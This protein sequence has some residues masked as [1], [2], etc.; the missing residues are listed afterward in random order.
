MDGGDFDTSE[1]RPCNAN[2]YSDGNL[3]VACPLGGFTDPSSDAELATNVTDCL[4]PQNSE[5]V[6]EVGLNPITQQIEPYVRA[7][8]CNKGYGGD[9]TTLVQCTQCGNSAYKGE[10][11]NVQCTACP[12]GSSIAGENQAATDIGECVCQGNSEMNA[13]MGRCER[14]P[15]KFR[16]ECSDG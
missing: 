11:G 4:C 16:N 8:Q 6:Y 2:H 14:L 15:R 13:A 12:T 5:Q 9:A 7:C 3:C 10:V 1:C